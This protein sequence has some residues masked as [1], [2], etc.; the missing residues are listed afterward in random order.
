MDY[1]DRILNNLLEIAGTGR[2]ANAY[3]LTGGTAEA[4][5]RIARAFAEALVASPA[6]LIEPPHEKPHLFS[7]EDVRTGINDSV[8]IRPYGGKKKVYLIKDAALMNEQAENALLKT[9]EE[10]P[11]YTVILLLSESEAV[12]LQTIRSRAVKITLSE[13]REA[14]EAAE[15]T[16]S[17]ETLEAVA[18]FLRQGTDVKGVAA[19][20][21]S[22][23]IARERG[24][25]EG[26][27]AH[28]MQ[29]VFKMF[30]EWFRDVLVV[31]SG[32]RKDLLLR[33]DRW[34]ELEKTAAH[35]RFEQAEQIIKAIDVAEKR[36]ESNVNFEGTVDA[37]LQT[38]IRI[39]EEDQ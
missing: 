13:G 24:T 28:R 1:N 34:N 35:L 8:A 3:L 16:V 11:A 20:A 31:K 12:F 21:L 27:S 22:K 15:E 30:R 36:L 39:Y 33:P 7:V 29:P 37:M 19:V 4:R 23:Q 10:P 18:A 32:G 2:A 9:L 6:D 38:V 14:G 17:S 5:Y 25:S 26:G